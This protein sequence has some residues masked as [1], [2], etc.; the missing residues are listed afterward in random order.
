VQTHSPGEHPSVFLVPFF[1]FFLAPCHLRRFRT[2]RTIGATVWRAIWTDPRMQGQRLVGR[3]R[4]CS[5]VMRPTML[6]LPIPS[7]L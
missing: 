2:S 3:N 4:S 7:C 1:P 6:N 5:L